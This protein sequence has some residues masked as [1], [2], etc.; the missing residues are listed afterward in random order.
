MHR[1]KPL[2]P[3]PPPLPP[4][5]AFLRRQSHLPPPPEPP[6]PPPSSVSATSCQRRSTISRATRRPGLNIDTKKKRRRT[7][8]WSKGLQY[9]VL[10]NWPPQNRP[11]HWPPC[12]SS[13]IMSFLYCICFSSSSSLSGFH[14]MAYPFEDLEARMAMMRS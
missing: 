9:Q 10:V 13:C 14:P 4:S 7:L 5:T 6:P 12:Q 1:I 11:V 8:Q 3:L 2:P